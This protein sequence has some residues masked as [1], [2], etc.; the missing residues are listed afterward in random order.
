M[1]LLRRLRRYL[2][3]K[4]DLSGRYAVSDR[5]GRLH[6]LRRLRRRLPRRRDQAGRVIQT[7]AKQAARGV[8]P[9]KLCFFRGYSSS[10]RALE[11][12][13]RGGRFESVYLHQKREGTDGTLSFLVELHRNRAGREASCSC[14]KRF[15][16]KPQAPF[17]ST[18]KKGVP[19][20]ASSILVEENEPREENLLLYPSNA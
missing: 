15:A 12:H 6:R 3:G 8:A 2:P 7:K 4:R 19:L 14:A 9:R 17:I 16:A 18:K 13:S 20:G 5:S 1:H 10:G 11:W